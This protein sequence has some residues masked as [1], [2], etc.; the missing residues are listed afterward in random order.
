MKDRPRNVDPGGGGNRSDERRGDVVSDRV[1]PCGQER[2]DGKV[3][4]DVEQRGQDPAVQ[5]VG[6]VER[7][8]L[9]GQD[10]AGG[11]A[12]GIGE[13]DAE[14]AVQRN[15]ED[16]LDPR[17]ELGGGDRPRHAAALLAGCSTSR[18]GRPKVCRRY[19]RRPCIR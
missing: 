5:D 13:G 2:K 17:G 19:Q 15:F 8:A 6:V 16:A 9:D 7:R 3:G 14:E 4:G 1:L 11:G 18:G 12:A 10:D